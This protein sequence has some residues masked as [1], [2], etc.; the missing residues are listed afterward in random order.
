MHIGIKLHCGRSKFFFRFII[1]RKMEKKKYFS[2]K[3]NEKKI[4]SDLRSV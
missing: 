1:T 2:F 3:P 4:G